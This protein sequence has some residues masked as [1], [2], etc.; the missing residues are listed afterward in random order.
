MYCDSKKLFTRARR[1]HVPSRCTSMV[2]FVLN[3][4]W[5]LPGLKF[6]WLLVHQEKSLLAVDC[7]CVITLVMLSAQ[8]CGVVLSA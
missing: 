5:H 7:I 1:I 2:F 6:I 3:L 4:I 8:E